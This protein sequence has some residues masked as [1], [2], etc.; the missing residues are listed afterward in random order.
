MISEE[1]MQ[2]LEEADR[3]GILSGDK[4][5]LYEEAKSRGLIGGEQKNITE[6]P[7]LSG[8]QNLLA[9]ALETSISAKKRSAAAFATA[10]NPFGFGDE[11]KGG[12]AAGTAKM[13]GSDE[14]I[15]DLYKQA[16]NTER[17]T[18]KNAQK[19]YPL[20]SLATGMMADIGPTG[21]ALKAAGLVG[22]SVKKLTG[23]GALMGLTTA[24][25]QNE[26]IENLPGEAILKT[27]EGVL[28]SV[29][30][31]KTLEGISKG[32]QI[33]K[34][35]SGK[36]KTPAE[37]MNNVVD[38]FSK[39]MTPEEAKTLANQ[40]TIAEKNNRQTSVADRASDA[41]QGLIRL[42]GKTPGSK[43]IINDFISKRSVGSN[44][45]VANA[46]NN[47]ISA[48]AYF[49]TLDEVSKARSV[50]SQPLYE[51]SYAEGNAK[52]QELLKP[53]VTKSSKFVSDDL[54]GVKK[55]ITTEETP[56]AALFDNPNIQKYIT[57]AKSEP[58]FVDPRISNNDFAVID[59]AKK[60][61]DD[62]IGSAMR[63]GE[64]E[65]ARALIGI[66]KQIVSKLEELSPTYKQ[67]R[68][69]FADE[70]SLINAQKEGLDFSKYRPEE[71]KKYMSDLSGGEKDAFKIGVRENLMTI[72]DKTSDGLSAARKIFTNP[73]NRE[74]LK[75]VFNN[76][77]EYR[78]FSRKMIDEVRIFD[79][80]Q[81]ILGG[82]RTDINM[83][84]ESQLIQKVA[85]GMF[86][87]MASM[88]KNTVSAI[89]NSLQKVYKGL[90]EKN[91]RALAEV[92]TDRKKSI[93]M[94]TRIAY[95]AE[96]PQQQ[97]IIKSALTNIVPF[98]ISGTVAN[99]VL[100]MKKSENNS[101]TE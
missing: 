7:K 36:G 27:A 58:L 18:T 10:T 33:I 73:E 38:I 98:M 85:T 82:S 21:K 101:E 45:R 88:V 79:T 15:T 71:L 40:L 13:L 57:K 47:K 84:D 5:A 93:D 68:Q 2:L 49:G 83:A 67:A 9:A 90:N 29:I 53:K 20:Q 87:P 3:R 50:L 19:E 35:L 11:L 28:G 34:N 30:G 92:I 8:K 62:E 26:D 55:E 76:P 86:T 32:Y 66:K 16:R 72:R 25:G 69:V 52:I 59:G 95:R 99:N 44:R 64:K 14:P 63:A 89:S 43:N 77:K 12:V 41:V 17:D 81:R 23:A 65:K 4:K 37:I 70:S 74:R 42:L 94:L 80:K 22:T 24:V 39:Y 51:Q 6:E 61:V 54:G 78:D 1:R 100:P 75:I 91:S 46:I 97:K 96:D 48:D 56:A 31:G 60:M